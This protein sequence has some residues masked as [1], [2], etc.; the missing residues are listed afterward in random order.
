M[1]LQILLNFGCLFFFSQFL[2]FI[3]QHSNLK[4][5]QRALRAY[6]QLLE[7]PNRERKKNA[8]LTFPWE[9]HGSWKVQELSEHFSTQ[10]RNSASHGNTWNRNKYWWGAWHGT[11]SVPTWDVTTVRRRQVSLKGL[12]W[13][14]GFFFFKTSGESG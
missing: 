2:C 8:V 11:T 1:E 6:W 13:W 12:K 5:Y 7:Q 3:I 14:Q 4:I 9:M 10:G